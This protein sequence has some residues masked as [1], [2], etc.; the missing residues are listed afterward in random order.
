MLSLNYGMGGWEKIDVI[1]LFISFAYGMGYVASSRVKFLEGIK[2]LGI[3]QKALM[4]DPEIVE[5]DRVFKKQSEN[6]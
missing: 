4:V 1:C 5:M 3:N 6:K 2:L